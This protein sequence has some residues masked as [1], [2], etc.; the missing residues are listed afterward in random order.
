MVPSLNPRLLKLPKGGRENVFWKLIGYIFLTHVQNSNQIKRQDPALY[1]EECVCY[2]NPF[3]ESEQTQRAGTALEGFTGVP[4]QAELARGLYRHTGSMSRSV[5]VSAMHR[6]A[7]WEIPERALGSVRSHLGTPALK[8]VN[9][10]KKSVV[11]VK[12]K[13]GFTKTIPW[14]ENP[15]KNKEKNVLVNPFLRFTKTTDFF[16]KI[17]GLK[18]RGS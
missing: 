13:N 9:F 16:T 2:G 14:T 4:L 8:T 5:I 12:S 6:G 1:P 11:L 18:G 7:I 15:G 10:N 3:K 17:L